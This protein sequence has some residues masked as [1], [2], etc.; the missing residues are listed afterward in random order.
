MIDE[1]EIAAPERAQ[2][3]I[4]AQLHE[5]GADE[6]VRAS[7]DFVEEAQ[8]RVGQRHFAAVNVEDFPATGDVGRTDE[9]LAIEPT[10]AAEGRVDRTRSG[11]WCRSRPRNRRG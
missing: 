9:N 2:S 3:G 11:W 6:A 10:G 5:V 8:G 4:A 1:V 7:R